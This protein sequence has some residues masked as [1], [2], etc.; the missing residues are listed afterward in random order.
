MKKK[1]GTFFWTSYSD[2]MT[3]LFF[4]MLILF[5]LSS[6]LL[7]EKIIEVEEAKAASEEQLKNIKTIQEAVNQLPKQYFEEDKSNQRWTLRAE[8]TPKFKIQDSDI[9]QV[10]DT[11]QLITVGN[12]LM[13]VVRQLNQ[14]KEDPKYS[15]MNITYLVV[16]EGMASKDSY[17]DNDGLSY[18]RAL[19]LYYLW[20]RNGISF[21]DSQCEVQISGSGIRG[22]GRYNY[23]GHK[24]NEEIKNQRII[25]QIVPK[26]SNL[27]EWLNE[28]KSEDLIIE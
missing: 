7:G 28:K 10:N 4:I 27:G 25:I 12:S 24:P 26:I 3:S 20:K 5:V 6:V 23:D 8:Y 15:E 9:T 17:Y 2:L 16:I 18:K 13:N 14:M 21:E 11:S 19:S 1:E 22:R